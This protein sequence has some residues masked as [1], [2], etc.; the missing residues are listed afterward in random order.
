VSHTEQGIITHVSGNCIFLIWPSGP[1][2]NVHATSRP[3]PGRG[4]GLHQNGRQTTGTWG[5][6]FHESSNFYVTLS[7]VSNRGKSDYP[8][9][10]SFLVRWAFSRTN[11]LNE[12]HPI[13][14]ECLSLLPLADFYRN[15][16][17][18][19]SAVSQVL[20]RGG[21]SWGTQILGW[22]NGPPARWR[23]TPI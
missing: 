23:V 19:G 5:L 11:R 21:R 17:C 13:L 12:A 7:A 20:R 14:N 9:I 6:G 1:L 16:V 22:E 10:F 18:R 4:S 8:E 15:F 3:L 2:C